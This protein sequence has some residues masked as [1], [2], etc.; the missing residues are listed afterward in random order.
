MTAIFFPLYVVDI[1]YIHDDYHPSCIGGAGRSSTI[2]TT[3]GAPIDPASSN[4]MRR[5]DGER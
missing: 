1:R 2:D 3:S 5:G 4:A